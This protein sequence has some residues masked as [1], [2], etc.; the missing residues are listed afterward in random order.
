MRVVRKICARWQGRLLGRP[1]RVVA[2]GPNFQRARKVFMRFYMYVK[3]YL[4]YAFI[5][6]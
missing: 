1:T 5:N 3:L 4:V 2:R 6:Y